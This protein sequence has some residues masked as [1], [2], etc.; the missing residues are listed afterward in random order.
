MLKLTGKKVFLRDFQ[1]S[2]IVCRVRWETEETE[3]QLWDG[4]W[5]YEGLTPEQKEE[6]LRAYIEKMKGWVQKFREMP[7]DEV[8]TGFQICAAD[9]TC[10]GWCN[11]YLIGDDYEFCENGRRRAIGIDIPE[12]AYRGQGCASEALSMLIVYL[13]EHGEKEIYTQ[14]WSGNSRMIG[15]AEKLGFEEIVRKPKVRSVRGEAYDGLTFRL[16]PARFQAYLDRC[17]A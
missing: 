15:L 10:I 14:T 9:G 6:E 17:R 1:E 16:N 11:T 8:R 12:T 3:W 4:P 5:E 13:L 2:D 7:D